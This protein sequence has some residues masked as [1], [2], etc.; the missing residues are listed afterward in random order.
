MGHSTVHQ[1]Y[2][3]SIL[4]VVTY[5]DDN[6][7]DD[8]SV[9]KL[10]DMALFSKFH[11]H[12]IFRG[13]TGETLNEFVKRRRLEKAVRMFKFHPELSVTDVA[14]RVGFNS[15]EHFS[16]SFRE[17]FAMSPRELKAADISDPSS[18]KNSKIYQ[19]LSQDSFYHVYL[20]SRELPEENFEVTIREQPEIC[21]A[22]ISEKFG[23]DGSGLLAAYQE[24]V[25]WARAHE[26]YSD[27]IT[28]F[29]I[30]RDDIE[31]TP[32]EHYR[33]EF[34]I[35]IPRILQ[36]NGRVCIDTLPGGTYALARVEGDIHRVAQ[37]WD[38]LYK[39]WL[40]GS[41]FL[42]TDHPAVEIFLQ[43]PEK[44]GWEL[45][46]LEIGFPVKKFN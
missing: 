37:A 7:E 28:R 18:A 15:P 24:L 36:G 14:L 22:T 34:G 31:V 25:E 3:E 1:E 5:V 46:D 26:W 6:L 35:A 32:A 30:S 40:P 29:A 39:H 9:E 20:K 12:R 44:I 16:R 41:G 4:R 45:F 11:F 2:A 42:P 8:L 43:G 13:L 27:D 10:A 19:V 33:M 21:I 17:R 23:K 38:Y